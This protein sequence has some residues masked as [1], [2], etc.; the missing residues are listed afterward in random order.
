MDVQE[1][2]SL[3]RTNPE[4]Y[5]TTGL[6]WGNKAHHDEIANGL[7]QALMGVLARQQEY[8]GKPEAKVLRHQQARVE[9][10][11]S[12]AERALWRNGRGSPRAME[13]QVVVLCLEKMA[14]AFEEGADAWLKAQ[15]ANGS[16]VMAGTMLGVGVC[17]AG[18]VRSHG[19]LGRFF[20]G[21]FGGLSRIADLVTHP[22]AVVEMEDL[23]VLAGMVGLARN[24]RVGERLSRYSEGG[25]RLY[26]ACERLKEKFQVRDSEEQSKGEGK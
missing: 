11:L 3:F 16:N 10:R 4:R 9:Q 20:I 12:V 13:N 19:A 6:D 21:P 1:R 15:E 14:D 18:T 22:D 7:F 8:R 26:E 23:P 17:M 5:A 24:V 25:A 2:L